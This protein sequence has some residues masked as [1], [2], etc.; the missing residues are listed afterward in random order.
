MDPEFLSYRRPE[1]EDVSAPGQAG[2][3]RGVVAGGNEH[4][5]YRRLRRYRVHDSQSPG[6]RGGGALLCVSA[7]PCYRLRRCSQLGE[8]HGLRA[9]LKQ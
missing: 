3:P 4:P 2:D 5:V 9:I 7:R 6:L 1:G 8:Q